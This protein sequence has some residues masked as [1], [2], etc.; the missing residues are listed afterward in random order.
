[1]NYFRYYA[2]VSLRAKQEVLERL[3]ADARVDHVDQ[4]ILVPTLLNLRIP[5][6]DIQ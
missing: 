2:R 1:M 5:I 6:R 4:R 3:M